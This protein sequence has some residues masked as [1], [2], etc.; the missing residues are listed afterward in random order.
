MRWLPGWGGFDWT[1]AWSLI[2]VD[3]CER[4]DGEGFDC[5]GNAS[6]QQ[7]IKDARPP[8]DP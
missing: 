4:I 8:A 1:D 2:G 7:R 5:D 3:G 6:Q